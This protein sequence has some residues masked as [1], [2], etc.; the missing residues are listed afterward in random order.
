MMDPRPGRE[1]LAERGSVPGL[2][3]GTGDGDG[4]GGVEQVAW[5]R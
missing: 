1:N 5:N 3:P 4:G 2:V